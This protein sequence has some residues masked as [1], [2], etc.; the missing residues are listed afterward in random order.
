MVEARAHATK[1][2]RL[3]SKGHKSPNSGMVEQG[4]SCWGCAAFPEGP[5]AAP[6]TGLLNGQ[7]VHW[8]ACGSRRDCLFTDWVSEHAAGL[9][10]WGG[11]TPE[12]S[13]GKTWTGAD[14]PVTRPAR[15]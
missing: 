8:H 13:N 6:V 14:G 1:I 10:A 11:Q 2:K 7:P 9:G 4:T 3:A 12:K 5:E 15:I